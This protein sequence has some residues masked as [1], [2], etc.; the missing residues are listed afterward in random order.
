MAVPT[1]EQII[2]SAHRKNHIDFRCVS[3]AAD[4]AIYISVIDKELEL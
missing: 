4:L 1:N 3:V 2:C